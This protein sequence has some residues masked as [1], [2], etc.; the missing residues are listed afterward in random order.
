MNLASDTN[1]DRRLLV[2][3]WDGLYPLWFCR[4]I[5]HSLITEL[6]VCVC[7]TKGF[8]VVQLFLMRVRFQLW[9]QPVISM[10]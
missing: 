1:C 7:Q 5:N 9:I 6:V 10:Y 4:L 2:N 3:L 8:K